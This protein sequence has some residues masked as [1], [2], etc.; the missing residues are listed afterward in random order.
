MTLDDAAGLRDA[1]RRKTA[2]REA[3]QMTAMFQAV[4]AGMG[5]KKTFETLKQRLGELNK[6]VN[7]Y[8]SDKKRG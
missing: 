3:S 2:W 8:G 7:D 6:Q 5:D 4:A 1:H